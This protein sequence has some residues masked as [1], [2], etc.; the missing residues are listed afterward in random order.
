MENQPTRQTALDWLRR[1]GIA[2]LP[3]IAWVAL[4]FL[5]GRRLLVGAQGPIRL[6]VYAFSTQEEVLTQGI[7]PAFQD[8]W[9]SEHDSELRIEGVF[10]PSATL[11][12]Q[13]NLGAPA[14]V[15]LFSN[16]HHVTWLQI[17]R[18]VRADTEPV[19]VG[20]TPI[21]IVTRP[22]NPAGIRDYADLT[23]PDLRLLHADPTSSGVGEWAILAVYGSALL[24]DPGS[25]TEDAAAVDQLEAVWRNVQLMAPSARA[26]MM[27]FELGAGDAVITYE[28]DALLALDRGVDLEIVM[29]SRTI[30]ACHVLALVDENISRAERPVAQAFVDFILCDDGQRILRAYHLRPPDMTDPG[31]APTGEVFTADDLG[32]WAETHR[33]LIDDLWQE[34]IEPRLELESGSV[35][36]GPGDG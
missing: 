9:E 14:D 26:V 3:V 13:I 11:A 36:V 22:G 16:A 17:G 35:L 23:R 4:I 20:C 33:R 2:L 27:L 1:H 8:A 34:Q 25:L 19:I 6:I 31:F 24:A 10:G 21:V 28:Q 15:T 12:G 30:A 5:G 29:P 7:L 32:G 18:R